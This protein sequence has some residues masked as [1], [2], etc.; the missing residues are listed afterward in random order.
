MASLAEVFE[1]VAAIAKAADAAK[2]ANW[3]GAEDFG[4]QAERLE[5]IAQRS[6]RAAKLLRAADKA[7]GG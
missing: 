6:A 3:D 2:E 1:D 7:L 5:D 4:D